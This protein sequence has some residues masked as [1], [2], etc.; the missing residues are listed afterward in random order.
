[1]N[2]SETLVIEAAIRRLKKDYPLVS[3]KVKEAMKDPNLRVFLDSWVIPALE[4]LAKEDR[5]RHDLEVA[6]GLSR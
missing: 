3:D 1:M 5:T 2:K 4:L 6:V